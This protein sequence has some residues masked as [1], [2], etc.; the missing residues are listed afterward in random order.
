MNNYEIIKLAISGV[1]L[2]I[3][4]IENVIL[5][6]KAIKNKHWE[7][8]RELLK[9]K[10]KPLMEQAE[11]AFS[12]PESKQNWVIK[13]LGEKLHI[14]FYKHKK[15]LQLV[16]EIITQLCEDTHLEVN[17]PQYVNEICE[18]ESDEKT[19]LY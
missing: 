10:I 3:T 12:D 17:K 6:V 14:D 11:R 2:L 18:V 13:K 1:L 5:I 19:T 8:L 16:I 15:V 9:D 4:I 7:E